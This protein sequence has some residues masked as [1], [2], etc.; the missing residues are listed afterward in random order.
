MLWVVGELAGE[1]VTAVVCHTLHITAIRYEMRS[2]N[3]I[4]EWK[5]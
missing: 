4:L 5:A 1:L 2:A 3:T